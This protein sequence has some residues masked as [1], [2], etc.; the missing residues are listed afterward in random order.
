MIEKPLID[1]K[2]TEVGGKTFLLSKIPSIAS[3]EILMNYSAGEKGEL[4]ADSTKT[5][6]RM[7]S[8]CS[9]D[10]AGTFQRLSTAEFIDAQIPSVKDLMKLEAEMLEYNFGFFGQGESLRSSPM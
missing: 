10:I 2:Q 5:I 8:Y 3:R 7:L 4:A 6:L 9:V 1:E